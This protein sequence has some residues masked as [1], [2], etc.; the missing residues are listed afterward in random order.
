[1]LKNSLSAMFVFW[2]A[3]RRSIQKIG[4]GTSQFVDCAAYEVLNPS[5]MVLSGDVQSDCNL[6]SFRRARFF[7]F[8]NI[9]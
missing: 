8:F 9:G 2:E 4:W 3:Y 7:D 6:G 5:E 1:M